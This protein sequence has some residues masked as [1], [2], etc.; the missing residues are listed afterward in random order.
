MFS[1]EKEGK[2]PLKL[3]LF[4]QQIQPQVPMVVNSYSTLGYE[5]TDCKLPAG[6]WSLIGGIPIKQ[7]FDQVQ[8]LTIVEPAPVIQTEQTEQNLGTFKASLEYSLEKFKDK[9]T[10][11]DQASLSRIIH[12]L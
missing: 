10:K 4:Q 3:F 9:L 6:Q 2:Q 12:K 11:T 1:L 7:I 5:I 8:T